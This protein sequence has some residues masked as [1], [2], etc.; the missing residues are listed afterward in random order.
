MLQKC[1]KFENKFHLGSVGLCYT[2]DGIL[3]R[4]CSSYLKLKYGLSENYTQ[5]A[6]NTHVFTRM[7]NTEL[8]LHLE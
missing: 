8:K 4:Q 6:S 5:S 3:W 7:G 1:V 2:K